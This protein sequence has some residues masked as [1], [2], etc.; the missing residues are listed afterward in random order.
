MIKPTGFYSVYCV[1]RSVPGACNR[2]VTKE[3]HHFPNARKL[4][5]REAGQYV[6]QDDMNM[7]KTQFLILKSRKQI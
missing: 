3:A 2:V 5:D 6:V 4:G 1:P 7:L